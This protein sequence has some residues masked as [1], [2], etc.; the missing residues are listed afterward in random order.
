MARPERAASAR[1]LAERASPEPYAVVTA[2]GINGSNA[3]IRAWSTPPPGSTH[4]VLIEEGAVLGKDF[5][6]RVSAAVRA[7]P[8]AALVLHAHPDTPAAA[9]VRMAALTGHRWAPG[10]VGAVPTTALVLPT[11]R[12]EGFVRYATRRTHRT[13]HGPVLAR[14]LRTFG[15]PT[16]LATA[17]HVRFPLP[18]HPVDDP[19]PSSRPQDAEV[20]T[21]WSRAPGLA[22]LDAV[23]FFVR[24]GVHV[25]TRIRSGWATSPAHHYLARL[26][27]DPA[28]YDRR[29]RLL[30]GLNSDAS[31]ELVERIGPELSTR[32]WL[33]AFL[34][35]VVTSAR[36]PPDGSSQRSTDGAATDRGLATVGVGGLS[37]AV[38]WLTLAE[39]R[40]S[41]LEVARE[42]YRAGLARGARLPPDTGGGGPRRRRRARRLV[43]TGADEPIGT[44]LARRLA[45]AGWEVTAVAPRLLVH[46]YPGVRELAADPVRREALDPVLPGA[47]A[48]VHLLSPETA[49]SCAADIGRLWARVENVVAGAAKAGVP[50]V[51]CVGDP[52]SVDLALRWGPAA[53]RPLWPA[54]MAPDG[55]RTPAP[56][57]HWLRLGLVFGPEVLDGSVV[58]QALRRTL[59]PRADRTGDET[60]ETW[61]PVYIDDV[62]DAVDRTLQAPP[63]H[64]IMNITG[65]ERLTTEDIAL[66]AARLDS[67]R[68]VMAAT[69]AASRNG[70]PRRGGTALGWAPRTGFDQGLAALAEWMELQVD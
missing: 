63:V 45:D 3:A 1:E 21:G 43:L 56:T 51:V 28:R 35:G 58:E 8:E 11:G 31:T 17:E 66:A 59:P 30:F 38:D 5:H 68:P 53:D 12:A 32:H 40:P 16:Y 60:T 2:R 10:V 26:G 25:A 14:Y 57:V 13:G 61:R 49:D 20:D 48:V 52:T 47:S 22:A 64:R 37:A 42:A 9:A 50:Q 24:G 41:L 36:L 23:P 4:H 27:L 62:V 46:D 54:A 15:V 70:G 7:A 65:D 67:G 34:M 18:F 19:A 29:L 6:A 33:T 39:L 69:T 44:A 55:V